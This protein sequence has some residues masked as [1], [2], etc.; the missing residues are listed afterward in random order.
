MYFPNWATSVIFQALS[1]K[2]G[3]QNQID[4]PLLNARER[5]FLSYTCTELNYKEI[6]NLMCCS[7]RTVEGYRD[8]LFEK[9]NLRT[10][11]GLAMYALQEGVNK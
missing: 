7:P 3:I 4:K 2:K 8:A 5:E 10:R 11:V 6:A 9:L 1:G